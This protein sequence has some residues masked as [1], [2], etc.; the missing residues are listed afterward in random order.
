MAIKRVHRPCGALLQYG[1]P[2][3]CWYC[4]GE[5]TT[6]DILSYGADDPPKSGSPPKPPVPWNPEPDTLKTPRSYAITEKIEQGQIVAGKIASGLSILAGVCGVYFLLWMWWQSTG[7]I[8][9]TPIAS[10]SLGDL[11]YGVFSRVA[12]GVIAIAIPVIAKAVFGSR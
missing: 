11:V 2:G 4:H 8:F 6:E 10:I 5:L 3:T 12:I 7:S 1:G 9:D